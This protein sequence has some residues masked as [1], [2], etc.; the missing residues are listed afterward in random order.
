MKTIY[1]II[2][3]YFLAA[4]IYPG[5]GHSQ[6]KLT[7]KETAEAQHIIVN[8]MECEECVDGELEAVKKLG[9]IAVPSL[10]KIL[11]EGPSKESLDLRRRHLITTYKELKKYGETHPESAIKMSEQEYVKIYMDNYIALYQ[12]R[13]AEALSAIG[14]LAAKKALED[15]LKIP[16]RDDVKAAVRDSIEK[17]K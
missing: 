9:E 5:L 4:W 8:W 1:F 16:L 11:P 6:E 13:A 3:T 7:L 10:S 2:L 12:I 15:S 17:L 14:G